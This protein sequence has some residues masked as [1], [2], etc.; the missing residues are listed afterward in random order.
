MTEKKNEKAKRKK[1]PILLHFK[2]QNIHT[3]SW[4][5]KI[6]RNCAAAVLFILKRDVGKS[7][8]DSVSV[9]RLIVND[10]TKPAKTITKGIRKHVPKGKLISKGW[11]YKNCVLN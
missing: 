7:A 11:W 6:K 8:V 5:D 3:H 4:A 9:K 2:K 10:S 1:K